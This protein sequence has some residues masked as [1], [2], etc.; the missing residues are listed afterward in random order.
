MVV[1]QG[2]STLVTCWD[3]SAMDGVGSCISQSTKRYLAGGY[4]ELMNR[5]CEYNGVWDV[6]YSCYCLSY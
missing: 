5:K 2:T 1:Q 3:V 4:G 6:C